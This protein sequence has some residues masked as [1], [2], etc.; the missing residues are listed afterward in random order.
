MTKSVT[1]VSSSSSLVNMFRAV[2]T[3]MAVFF[4]DAKSKVCLIHFTATLAIGPGVGVLFVL[5]DCCMSPGDGGDL[6]CCWLV[7][8]VGE[9]TSESVSSILLFLR[10][11][12]SGG[13]GIQ[14]PAFPRGGMGTSGPTD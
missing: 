6:S 14:N 11:C 3:G 10:C 9:S 13:V 8:C 5:F 1:A 2:S 7:P 4:V 12:P